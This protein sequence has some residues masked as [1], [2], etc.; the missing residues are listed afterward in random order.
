MLIILEAAVWLESFVF[1]L[2]LRL[3]LLGKRVDLVEISRPCSLVGG[4]LRHAR[5]ISGMTQTIV[6]RQLCY[7]PEIP[8]RVDERTKAI[9]YRLPNSYS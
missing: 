5:D 3:R 7:I 6:S 9:V 4:F 8:R 1:L 2:K